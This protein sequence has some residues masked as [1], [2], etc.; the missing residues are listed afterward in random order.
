MS[1]VPVPSSERVDLLRVQ[2]AGKEWHYSIAVDVFEE[3]SSWGFL[4]ADVAKQIAD[5]LTEDGKGDRAAILRSIRA[6]FC[7]DLDSPDGDGE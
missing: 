2:I 4:L 3:P 6:T 7:E 1:D 5:G